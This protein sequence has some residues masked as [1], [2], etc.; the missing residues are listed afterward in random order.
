MEG[1]VSLYTLGMVAMACVLVAMH[2][3]SL[4]VPRGVAGNEKEERSFF[5]VQ[6]S[7]IAPAAA[8]FQ[9]PFGPISLWSTGQRQAACSL[10][11]AMW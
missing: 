5:W 8:C 9:A 10:G 4:H 11:A 1:G 6:M 7:E 2:M 3:L